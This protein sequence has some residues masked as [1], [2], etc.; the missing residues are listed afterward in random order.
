[1]SSI[2]R[3]FAMI[4]AISL[5]SICLGIPCA[6]SEENTGFAQELDSLREY[7]AETVEPTPE[8]VMTVP[9]TQEG[10]TAYS[11]GGFIYFIW[12][13]WV[14][15]G[16][17]DN[18]QGSVVAR[19]YSRDPEDEDK[20]DCL[21]MVVDTSLRKDG[22]TPEDIIG[23][24]VLGLMMA[25]FDENGQQAQTLVEWSRIRGIEGVLITEEARL[26]AWITGIG[27]KAIMVAFSGSTLSM[28]EMRHMLLEMLGVTEDEIETRSLDTF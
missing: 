10:M 17:D 8:P 12:D 14:E 22:T 18:P 15:V 28:T 4:V 2:Q 16:H 20:T 1:M 25:A 13:D 24:F 6:Q 5:F 23:D 21:I 19:S 26:S 9:D 27:S 11:L 3:L 7:F